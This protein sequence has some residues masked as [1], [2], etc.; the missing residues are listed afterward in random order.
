MFQ[1]SRQ[2]R[3]LILLVLAMAIVPVTIDGCAGGGTKA[4]D[5]FQI[6]SLLGIGGALVL[7][8]RRQKPAANLLQG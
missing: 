1:L 2:T 7:F 8:S 5:A 4:K 6:V 3:S